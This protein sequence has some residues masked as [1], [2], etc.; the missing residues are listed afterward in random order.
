[1]Y[2]NRL[3]VPLAGMDIDVPLAGMDNFNAASDTGKAHCTLV[4]R[5]LH[6]HNC[7]TH[8]GMIHLLRSSRV[9]G[10]QTLRT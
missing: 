10:T 9:L 2:A 5:V 6:G 1:M 7:I 3:D 8:L 4:R